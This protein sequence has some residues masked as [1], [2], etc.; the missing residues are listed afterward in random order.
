V[1]VIC[2]KT[3]EV[4]H[5]LFKKEKV[6]GSLALYNFSCFSHLTSMGSN[7]DSFSSWRRGYIA[8]LFR[9]EKGIK[10]Y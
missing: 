4:N 10:R 7:L 1:H 3:Y 2:A 5:L 8:L 6:Y 9:N